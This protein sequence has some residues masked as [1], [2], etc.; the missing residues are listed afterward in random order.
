MTHSA[1]MSVEEEPSVR[2]AL[3]EGHLGEQMRAFKMG[4]K[5]CRLTCSLNSH[6]CAQAAGQLELCNI[7][8]CQT[9]LCS[10]TVISFECHRRGKDDNIRVKLQMRVCCF[11]LAPAV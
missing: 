2:R 5:L 4:F 3:L 9:K 11:K 7:I 10:T 1:L 6:A 8:V